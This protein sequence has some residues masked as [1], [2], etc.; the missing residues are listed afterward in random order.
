MNSTPEEFDETRCRCEHYTA[1][2]PR[3]HCPADHPRVREASAT[4][5][6]EL[7]SAV[8]FAN[9][10]LSSALEYNT[11]PALLHINIGCNRDLLLKPNSSLVCGNAAFLRH[12]DR[13]DATAVV[14][15]HQLPS[16]DCN[17]HVMANRKVRVTWRSTT[18]IERL[19]ILRILG[20]YQLPDAA[21]QL[22]D[23]L[24]DAACSRHF[25]AVGLPR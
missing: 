3:H 7:L 24:V 22:I 13:V 1:D 14:A 23:S 20:C 15:H 25:S 2:H 4:G 8:A 18:D 5:G 12:G 17:I 6:R 10:A 11:E 9:L 19:P 21:V 16:S